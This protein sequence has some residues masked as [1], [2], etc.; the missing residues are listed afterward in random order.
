VPAPLATADWVQRHGGPV[1][2]EHLSHRGVD[3]D[4]HVLQIGAAGMWLLQ[5][6]HRDDTP[7]VVA[8]LAQVEILRQVWVQQFSYDHDGRLCWRQAKASRARK[9]R[10]GTARRTSSDADEDLRSAMVP[11]SSVEIVTPHDPQARFSHKPG[12]IEWIGYKD[13][14][15]E[16]CD[17][18]YPDVIVQVL[19]TP[20]TEQDFDALPVIHVRLSAQDLAPAQHLVDAGYVTPRATRRAVTDHDVTIVGPIRGDPRAKD[21]PGFAKADF[22]S[23]GK[24]KR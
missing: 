6:V 9:T 8:R 17:D 1:H 12:K 15:T 14:Q 24:R 11:W 20:A 13:H 19:T 5:Q 3:S 16:T 10:D 18:G 22:M 4:E 2:G 7:A 23:T 21:R